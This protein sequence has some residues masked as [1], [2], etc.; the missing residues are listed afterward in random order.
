[1]KKFFYNIIILTV[2]LFTISCSNQNNTQNN[3]QNNNLSN[4]SETKKEKLIVAMEGL[5]PPFNWTQQDDSNGAIL[6]EGTNEYVGGYDVEIAKKIA[7]ELDRDLV[8]KK[9]IWDGLI[10]A[11]NAN[12]VDLIIAGM[13]PTSER[14]NAIDFS[15]NYYNSDLVVIVRKDGKFKDAKTLND[16]KGAKIS[17]Q[18]NTLHYDVIDQ[19][20]DVIKVDA[21]EDFTA[22]R[23]ALQS[24]EGF[25][26]GYIS[27]RP[28]GISAENAIDKFKMIVLEDG[29]KTS[30][31]NTAIAI[32]L[33][34]GSPLTE[35][36]NQA[37]LKI[38]QDER[39]KI[40]ENAIKNQPSNN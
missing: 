33:K 15:D 34:K 18:L 3:Q 38:S 2:I 32:G 8:I 22:L 36:I 17:A 24:G 37:L 1:M 26:D 28:E 25:I 7:K 16:F 12:T 29:F 40:M 35:Q 4:D 20:S 14:K 9:I 6:V 5:Y 31:D 23:L 19:M 21:L 30:E 39:D 13:S 27:E 10:P 11:V